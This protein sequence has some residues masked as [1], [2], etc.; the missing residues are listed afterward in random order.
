M[1]ELKDSG[2][3]KQ[4][5]SGAVRDIQEGKGRCDLLP[6][7][8]ASSL[9]PTQL[10]AEILSEIHNF[11][12]YKQDHHLFRAIQAFITYMG[13]DVY[14]ALLEV[15]IHYEDGCIKYGERNWEKGIDLHCYINSGVR[16]LL[17]C[18]RGDK[19]EPHDR[20]F[21]WNMLGAIYTFAYLDKDDINLTCH[22]SFDEL[23]PTFVESESTSESTSSSGS[24]I[25][26]VYTE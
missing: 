13:W 11:M 8:I 25:I 18:F 21:I 24:G 14:T 7:G 12:Q 1:A 17:K 20:A 9:M 26:G 22:T 5:N 3:R 10:Q 6:I 16:H 23:V 2:E 15:S 4:F 19:D